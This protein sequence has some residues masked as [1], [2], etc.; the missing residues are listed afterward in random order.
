MKTFNRS[1]SLW[2]MSALVIVAILLNLVKMVFALE[3]NLTLRNGLRSFGDIHADQVS[4]LYWALDRH[5]PINSDT[6]Q[7][8]S[9]SMTPGKVLYQTVYHSLQQDYGTVADLAETFS[10]LCIA[11]PTCSLLAGKAMWMLERYG[12]ADRFWREESMWQALVARAPVVRRDEI[13]FQQ[14]RQYYEVLRNIHPERPEAH[15][16]LGTVNRSFGRWQESVAHFEQA[17]LLSPRHPRYQCALGEAL[18]VTGRDVVRG[19]ALCEEALR[20]APDDLWLYYQAGVTLAK[21]GNCV[22]ASA[23]FQAAREAFSSR[24]EPGKWWEK[25]RQGLIGK[26]ASVN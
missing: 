9:S 25:Y 11:R 13:E 2:L 17:L 7:E 4:Q 3:T 8:P 12:A 26:C 21:A 14:L 6:F 10:E 5:P 18:V 24:E 19:V 1:T 23:I 22:Q 16:A 15:F 20:F